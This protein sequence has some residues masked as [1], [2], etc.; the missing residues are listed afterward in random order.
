MKKRNDHK[1]D[2][3]MMKKRATLVYF[4]QEFPRGT[5][6]NN[7]AVF[8]RYKGTPPPPGPLTPLAENHFVKTF[9]RNGGS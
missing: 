1:C 5:V 3:L 9:S 8:F 6:K 2:S 4:Q 7:F